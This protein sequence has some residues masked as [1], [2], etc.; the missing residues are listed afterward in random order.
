MQAGLPRWSP[1]GKQ[2]AF[3]GFTPDK[4]WMMYL[5]S[6]SGGSP[7]EVAAGEGDIGWSPDGHSVVFGDTP[8]FLEPGHSRTFAIH[9]MD[10]KTHQVSTL[11]GSQG[12]YG[13]RWSPN[14]RYVAA[15][16]AGPETL[17]IFDFVTRKW[18]ELV[19]TA[20]GYGNWSRDGQHFYFDSKG[21]EPAFYRV[22]ISDQKLEKLV[23][24]KNLRLAGP[25]EWTGL[26]PDDSPLL[27]RDV[28]T[29]EIYALDWEAP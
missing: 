22:R 11:P 2:I 6:A 8:L 16:R 28:G 29:Q 4:T 26:G 18:T 5:M 24:L 1:D 3:Q 15:E 9:V 20:T 21:P 27:L 7:Q 10:L 19:T 17:E 13:P 25:G 14:G 23:S 12:L